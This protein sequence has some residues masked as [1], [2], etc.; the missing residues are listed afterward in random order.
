MSDEIMII[1]EAARYLG[2][3]EITIRRWANS[4]ELPCFRAG[5][6]RIRKFYKKD[7]DEFC[8][9]NNVQ[10]DDLITLE[11]ASK[12]LGISISTL[13]RKIK[14]GKIEVVRSKYKQQVLV[15]KSIIQNTKEEYNV[16]QSTENN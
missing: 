1:S 6:N 3:S 13:R 7:L 16:G 14:S 12:E 10:T 11:E 2:V 4:R 8:K 5:H 9:K 15:R